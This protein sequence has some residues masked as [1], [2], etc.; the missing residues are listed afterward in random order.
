MDTRR[1]TSVSPSPG[2]GEAQ[3][4]APRHGLFCRREPEVGGLRQ[5]SNGAAKAPTGVVGSQGESIPISGKPQLEEGSRQ[6]RQGPRLRAGIGHQRVGQSGLDPQ[7]DA[8][9]RVLDHRRQLGGRQRTD[10][11][12]IRAEQPAQRWVR[13]SVTVMV[14]SHGHDHLQPG[15]RLCQKVNEGVSLVLIR[16]R[17]EQLFELIDDQE[18]TLTRRQSTERSGQAFDSAGGG[19]RRRLGASECL[20]ELVHRM[21]ARPKQDLNPR[22]APGQDSPLERRKEARAQDR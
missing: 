17:G 2:S 11:H 21:A 15:T 18:E 20:G 4:D 10:K 14:G 7:T 5:A 22:T 6:Q 13:S 9:R 19:V 1:R 12:L 16:H 3:H 8:V